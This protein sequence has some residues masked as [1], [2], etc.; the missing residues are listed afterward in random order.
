MKVISRVD[1][2]EMDENQL[3]RVQE[4]QD[5]FS[6][7]FEKIKIVCKNSRETSL[8]ITKLEEALMWLTKGISREGPKYSEED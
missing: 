3:K 5:E 1:S 4:L 8:G 2:V 6:C 7:V